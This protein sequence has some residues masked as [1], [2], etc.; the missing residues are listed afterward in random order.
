MILKKPEHLQ[1]SGVVGDFGK[2]VTFAKKKAGHLKKMAPPPKSN[3]IMLIMMIITMITI[4]IIMIIIILIIMSA[5]M[6]DNKS[7]NTS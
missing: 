4:M 7:A 2:K 3:I 5:N 1:N 6:S